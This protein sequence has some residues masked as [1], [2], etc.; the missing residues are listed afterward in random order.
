MTGSN[1]KTACSGNMSRKKQRRAMRM[2][3]KYSCDLSVARAVLRGQPIDGAFSKEAQLAN[4][5]KYLRELGSEGL[6]SAKQ[7]L[8]GA[9]RA[10]NRQVGRIG[11]V[12][13]PQSQLQGLKSIRDF[14]NNLRG[15]A[16]SAERQAAGLT[17]LRNMVHRGAPPAEPHPEIAALLEKA[18]GLRGMQAGAKATAKDW[19]GDLRNT[20]EQRRSKARAVGTV[21]APAAAG[22]VTGYIAG[23]G[24]Q[25]EPESPI[26]QLLARM[27]GPAG[28]QN[29]S[30][31][32]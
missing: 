28:Q 1:D 7:K 9:G 30:S 24:E 8:Q 13:A 32:S 23:Q 15:E 31:S 19:I 27:Y 18:K 3:H 11:G 21:A 10:V 5:L 4:L 25:K 14:R 6:G 26:R 22:G 12:G 29:G 17:N 2:A 16:Q 20:I